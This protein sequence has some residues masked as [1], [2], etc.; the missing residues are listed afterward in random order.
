VKDLEKAV[1]KHSC[2]VDRLEKGCRE[3]EQ[4]M[5]VLRTEIFAKAQVKQ[6]HKG[7]MKVAGAAGIITGL[8]A[9]GAANPFIAVP[10]A[11]V[12]IAS[13]AAGARSTAK[14]LSLR[15][16]IQKLQYSYDSHYIDAF[17]KGTFAQLDAMQLHAEKRELETLARPL[18]EVLDMKKAAEGQK[19]GIIEEDDEQVSIAG[20]SLKK[21][22]RL[23]HFGSEGLG[24]VFPHR[25]H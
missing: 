2:E 18:N 19:H 23:G 9:M 12:S 1:D 13:L 25:D 11:V 4:N 3:A 17:S 15:S 20:I 8:A 22:M 24:Y 14:V 16:E 5:A 7:I 6:T 21:N 10:L